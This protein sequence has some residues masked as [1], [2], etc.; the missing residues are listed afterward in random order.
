MTCRTM[1]PLSGAAAM[2]ALLALAGCT[3]TA[4]PETPAPG[5]C[6]PEAAE[7][8]AGQARVSDAQALRLTGATTVRQIAPGQPVTEDYRPER[9]TVATDPATG[10]IV[11]A[12]CG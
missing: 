6:N 1:K 5:L 12:S 3:A 2:A 9:V 10:R 7:R 8:M 11:S 4:Q